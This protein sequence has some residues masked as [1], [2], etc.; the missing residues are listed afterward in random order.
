[1]INS[2]LKLFNSGIQD[3]LATVFSWCCSEIPDYRKI[4][5]CIMSFHNFYSTWTF[6]FVFRSV[7]VPDILC[8][9]S[10]KCQVDKYSWYMYLTAKCSLIYFGHLITAFCETKTAIQIML[11]APVLQVVSW[12][13]VNF[14]CTMSC[15]TRSEL[16][17][18]YFVDILIL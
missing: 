1:M 7:F 6:F 17:I 11:R 15:V 2:G 5:Q 16:V 13:K 10:V 14:H 4:S 18:C 12:I 9:V 8:V 3:S